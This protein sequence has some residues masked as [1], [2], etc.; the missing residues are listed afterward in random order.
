MSRI[1]VNIT[2]VRA[3]NT[4]IQS[5]GAR[6]NRTRDVFAGVRSAIDSRILGQKGIAKRHDA[7][8]EETRII[9][10]QLER[11]RTFVDTSMMKYAN[12]EASLIKT[13]AA[14]IN[15]NGR[16]TVSDSDMEDIIRRWRKSGATGRIVEER[17]LFETFI[18]DTA[19]FVGSAPATLLK[20]V[21]GYDALEKELHFVDCPVE[22]RRIRSRFYASL[23]PYQNTSVR[24]SEMVYN[25]DRRV[26]DFLD[27]VVNTLNVRARRT[28]KATAS[29]GAF[30]KAL[31]SLHDKE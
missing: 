16:S 24:A 19:F 11:L 17:G 26:M 27:G 5:I 4:S 23:I 20:F 1:S 14:I 18:I 21:V 29:H 13:S 25:I 3:M 9:Q 8:L 12:T 10:E 15:V 22:R 7:L 31:S 28:G 2:A 6:K 30:S